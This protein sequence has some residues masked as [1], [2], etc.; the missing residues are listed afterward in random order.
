MSPTS[1]DT[2][3][4]APEP[5][6]PSYTAYWIGASLLTVVYLLAL[7]IWPPY[8]SEVKG[9]H[10][11]ATS[12]LFFGRFHPIAVHMPIGVIMLTLLI[13]LGSLRAAF[14]Q[15]WRD[16]AIFCGFV[17]AASSV[18][19]VM[20]GIFLAREGGYKG[21]AYI[22][23]QALGIGMTFGVIIAL[24]LR[25]IASQTGVR[26]FLDASRFFLFGSFGVMSL[27]A[28]F[29][30]NMVHGSNY[31]VEYAPPA[32]AK[33]LTATEK[34]MMSFF[35]K[36]EAPKDKPA[37]APAVA[38]PN[39]PATQP[40]ASN[41]TPPPAADPAKT[42]SSPPATAPAATGGGDKLVFR[43]VIL[44]IFEAKCNKCHN[45]DKSKG[46]LA[47]HT[48]EALMKGGQ[49]EST[50]SVVPGK[51]GDSLIIQRI[52]LPDSDDEHM[53]PE[54]KDQMTPEETSAVELWIKAGA[55]ETQKVSGAGLPPE[56]L[57][58]LN[59]AAQP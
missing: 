50:K 41:G 52:H 15:K 25:L 14:E 48:F 36:K 39:K 57:K 11:A 6:P 13:E 43:D 28:H 10:K 12:V 38:T 5:Q 9:A 51:P 31:L 17:T 55:S 27:G 49:D 18:V 32:L 47:M 4:P 58:S 37:T 26:T 33:P 42:P 1:Y 59:L 7:L 30:G 29:G 16:M 45:A 46:D 56:L 53:P 40:A 22:L 35:E 44:P 20:F 21:G 3:Y 8:F 54:G 34:W 23:H 19:A 2:A 24:F